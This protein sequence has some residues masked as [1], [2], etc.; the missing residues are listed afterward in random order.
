MKNIIYSLL[1]II[2]IA[3][4]A[5]C[6]SYLE[7]ESPDKLTSDKFWR[8]EA[9][10][11]AGLSSAYSQLESFIGWDEWQEGRPVVEYYRNDMLVPGADAFNYTWWTDLYNFSYTPGNYALNLVW[12]TNYRGI[13]FC[14]QVLENVPSI[15]EEKISTETRKQILAEAKFLRA[16]YHF[17]LLT[18]YQKVIIRTEVPK[19]DSDLPKADSPRSEVYDFI[20]ADLEDAAMDLVAEQGGGD[21]GR[22]TKGAANAYLGKVLLH[23]SGEENDPS[24]LAD[25]TTALNNVIQS[26]NYDLEDN[27]LSLFDG[28]NE[29]SSEAVFELQLSSVKDGGANYDMWL[30]YFMGPSEFGFW[31]EIL[32]TDALVT[33]MKKE[34]KV[35]NSG[36]YDTRLY[37]TCLFRDDYFNDTNNP[38][39]YGDTY[40]GWFGTSTSKINMRKYIPASSD[41]F[42]DRSAVNMPLMRYADVLLMYAEI[43]NET[44]QTALAIPIINKVRAEHG[45]MPA[46]LG[47]TKAEVSAQIEHERIMEFTLEGSRFPDLRRWGKLESA[48]STANRLGFKGAEHYYLPVPEGEVNSN[49]L[50]NNN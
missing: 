12:K 3:P 25:A 10:A 38:N 24:F 22:A 27:F 47:S 19:G 42:E 44:G 14:N 15:P 36:N 29:N 43:L 40:D 11:L 26:A 18:H 32:G 6:D 16:Y 49:P 23:R 13:N 34:G 21:I 33:E 41:K 31:E 9:D 50:I 48:M 39:V 37:E 45:D 2:F 8:N 4:F 30:Q 20:I 5:G 35:S 1:L 28:S 46:M 7:Q 17:K